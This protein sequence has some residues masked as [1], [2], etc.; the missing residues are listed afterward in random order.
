[1]T[2]YLRSRKRLLALI[3]AL[4]VVLA[5]ADDCGPTDQPGRSTQRWQ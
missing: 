5:V 1:M 4:G 2:T 3:A